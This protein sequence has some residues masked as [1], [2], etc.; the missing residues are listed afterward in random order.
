MDRVGLPPY[1]LERLL[2]RARPEPREEFVRGLRQTLLLPRIERDRHHLRVVMA[3]WALATALAVGG[4]ALSVVGL[5]PLTSGDR[6]AQAGPR[7]ETVLTERR[8]RRP[9]FVRASGGELRVRYRTEQVPRV[10]RR[11]R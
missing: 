2:R 6:P 5:L 10:V 7:C 1:E 11:C 8:A 4:L 3:G 9:Y